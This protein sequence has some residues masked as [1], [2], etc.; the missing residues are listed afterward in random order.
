MRAQPAQ[1]VNTGEYRVTCRDGSVRICELYAT[2]LDENLIVTFNDITERTWSEEQVMSQLQELQRWHNVMLGGEDR[3]QKL[4]REVNELCRRLGETPRYA[5]QE[6]D[7][8]NPE[9][10]NAEVKK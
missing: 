2:F 4:K 8:G 5:S 3:L 7:P 6:S 9:I 1:P 10:A